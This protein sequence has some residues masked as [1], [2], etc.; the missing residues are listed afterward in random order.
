MSVKILSPDWN[1]PNQIKA[2]VTTRIGGVSLA[3]YESMN[4]AS[5]VGD[6]LQSVLENRKIIKEQLNFP[7]EPC[8]LD[9]VHGTNVMTLKGSAP[10]ITKADAFY[11]NKKNIVGVVLTADCL[12]VLITND[13]GTEI[14][15]AHAGW[16]GLLN[17]V[18]EE[19]VKQFTSAPQTLHVWLGPAIGPEQFEVG[20]DVREGFLNEGT[21]TSDKV[22]QAFKVKSE[23]K[24]LADIYLLA[25]QRLE[26][27]GVE[28]ISGGDFCTVTESEK[29]YSFRRDGPTGRMASFIWIT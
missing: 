12:P 5:H 14:A 4:L 8:W 16:K 27:L 13:T 25:R 20:D 18:I 26:I 15:V 1:V 9:Q 28:N 22:K 6:D 29:F 7:N 3:P 2:Y 24:W 23:Q 17:G 10:L 11:T 19:T 21:V